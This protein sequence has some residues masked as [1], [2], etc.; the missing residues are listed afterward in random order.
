MGKRAIFVCLSLILLVT[1]SWGQA[2]A[3]ELTVYT[4][5]NIS[6]IRPAFSLYSKETGV[7]IKYVSKTTGPILERLERERKDTPAD[8]VIM[9]DAGSLWALAEKGLL[10]PISSKTL[11]KNVPAHLRDTKGRWFGLSKRARTAVYSRERVDPSELSTY[12][13]LADKKWKG[14]LCLRTSKKVYNQSLVAIMLAEHG[15]KWTRRTVGG[16][17][18]NL[19][20]G[21]FRSDD[22]AMMA[23]LAGRC[24]ITIVN[25]YYF[26]RQQKKNPSF[27]LDNISGVPIKKGVVKT[28]AMPL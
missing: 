14:R 22:K 12:E 26:G 1:G 3:A 15:E 20:T 10:V 19:A 8:L 16:W 5:R 11:K 17:V 4:E 23:V 2:H 9:N 28:G 18:D 13:D 24:D 25:S 21:P 7:N 6:L 27:K